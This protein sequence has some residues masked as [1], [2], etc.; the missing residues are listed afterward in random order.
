MMKTILIL[1]IS[2]ASTSYSFQSQGKEQPKEIAIKNPYTIT[3][4]VQ[5]EVEAPLIDP[6]VC[7]NNPDGYIYFQ[8]GDEVFRYTKNSP[9]RISRIDRESKLRKDKGRQKEADPEGC[10]GNP[11]VGVVIGY[12]YNESDEKYKKINIDKIYVNE[13]SEKYNPNVYVGESLNVS[14]YSSFKKSNK[15][16]E[17]LSK[18][19]ER[20]MWP[21]EGEIKHWA[22]IYRVNNESHYRYPHI[23]ECRPFVGDMECHAFYRIYPTFKLYYSFFLNANPNWDELSIGFFDVYFRN[24][25]EKMKVS[26]EN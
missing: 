17:V 24:V 23:L 16:C 21:N 26:M 10:K 11:Y 6:S 9:I 8:V 20:C 5:N 13:F 22:K 15:P 25:F 1:L 4:V 2:V 19:V 12:F 7:K 3:D 14:A 18:D